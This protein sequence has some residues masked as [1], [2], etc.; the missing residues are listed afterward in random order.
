M[1]FR[2][3][4]VAILAVSAGCAAMADSTPKDNFGSPGWGGPMRHKDKGA[5]QTSTGGL[6]PKGTNRE[7]AVDFAADSIDYNADKTLMIG[8]GNV[9]VTQGAISLKADYMTLNKDSGE[10]FARGNVVYTAGDR[11]WKGDQFTYN[12]HQKRGTF[13]AFQAFVPPYFLTAEDSEQITTNRYLL[14]NVTLTTCDGSNPEF[15]MKM[16]EGVL[17][18]N[19]DGDKVIDAKGVTAEWGGVT[20]FWMPEMSRVLTTHDAWWEFMPGYSSRHG[21][22]LLTAY[23]RHLSKEVLSTTRLDLRSARGVAVGEDLTWKDESKDPVTHRKNDAWEGDASAY[24]LHDNKPFKNAKEEAE[25]KDVEDANRY[26]LKLN[27]RQ[28]FSDSDYFIGSVNYLSDPNVLDDFFNS[29]YRRGVQ[30]ENRMTF[31]H[32]GDDYTASIELNKRLNDFYDNVDRLPELRL[33]VN[34]LELGDSGLYYESH[35][36]GGELQRV[37]PNGGTNDY[38]ALR[39]DTAH[40]V[41]YPTRHFGFLNFTPRAG[42]DGTFYS[43]TYD[44]KP[45]S[46]LDIQTDTNGVT[47]VKTNT[48]IQASDAGSGVRSLY[49][50]G[51]EAS[52]KAFKSWDDLTVLEG[53]DGLRHVA[54]PYLRYT[55]IPEPNLRPGDLPQFDS[56]DRLD[57]RN[58]IQIGMRNKLQTRYDKSLWDLADVDVYT[59][60]RFYKAATN[61]EDF[62]YIYASAQLRLLRAMPIDFELAYDE[63]NTEINQFNTQIS[64]LAEDDTLLGLE[65]RSLKGGEDFITPFVRLFPHEKI[66][67]DAEWRHDFKLQRLEEQAYFVH[68]NTTCM[69]YGLGFRDTTSTSGKSDMQVWATVSLLAFPNSRMSLGK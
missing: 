17:W 21:A 18:E 38:D 66:G 14:K 41:Y 33:D 45:V 19:E 62:D 54:E 27:H 12:L 24:Y 11:V 8:R 40:T 48:T 49:E 65:Y 64:Y 37:F 26:R 69:Q 59:Y 43:T 28:S 10:V 50:L 51:W 67:F 56:I 47:T 63:Y 46:T 57:Q 44:H 1:R 52:F 42:Y 9:L 23:N 20:V 15:A 68:Y 55:Y 29:E 16:H 39:L 30:P 35:N 3:G 58:D 13:G 25:F 34:R 36:S 22:F 53:G 60:Y 32:R 4:F 5:A 61:M 7:E 2:L 6:I 31:T